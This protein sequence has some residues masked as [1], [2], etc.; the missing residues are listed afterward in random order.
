MT[1]SDCRDILTKIG[2]ST[3]CLECSDIVF[4]PSTKIK[5]SA[6][7][8]AL[9]ISSTH[10]TLKT[11]G[12]TQYSLKICYDC[13]VNKFPEV[14]QK[15][16]SK[17]FNTCNV[18]VKYAFCVSDDDYFLQ[19]SKHGVTLSSLIKKY[20]ED[21]GKSRWDSYCNLQK[22]TNTF[23]Y[24]NLKYGM[25]QIEFDLF[26]KSRAVTLSNLISKYGKEDGRTR[27]ESYINKQAY[28]N[29]L[30]YYISKYGIEK[31]T[32]V[33]LEINSKKALT[34][35]NYVKRLGEEKGLIQYEKV[36]RRFSSPNTYSKVSQEFFIELDLLI[37]G[38]NLT[39]YYY[40]KSG[41]FGKV[42]KLS[43][44]YCKLD[45]YIKELSLAIEYYGVYWHASP[46]KYQEF[47]TVH[48]NKSASQIWEND[49]LRNHALLSEYG[50]ETIVV[51][52]DDDYL[53]RKE[54][55]KKLHDEIKE[56]VRKN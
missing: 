17:L 12:K 3:L 24:K 16:P 9:F 40:T 8:E 26:N 36:I 25:S 33:Y 15:N 7:N 55:L 34:L 27:W 42:L 56:R 29:T 53:N 6:A 51:W 43:N 23:E 52:Q 11:I 4:Y 48:S 49:R 14:T 47:D 5:L 2:D 39:T 19:R 18:Y 28:T 13:L 45:F 54:I 46:R 31:G 44:S 10:K 1:K 21:D 22:V 38:L 30:D 37:S 50:I 35:S 32:S 41:E 20:G